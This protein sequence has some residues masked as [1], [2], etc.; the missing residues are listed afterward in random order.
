MKKF[1]II[2]IFFLF[3]IL[4]N[5]SI[6]ET[7]MAMATNINDN[8]YELIFKNEDLNFRN[9]KLKLGIFTSYEYK[10]TKVYIDYKENIKEY[11]VDKEYISFDNTNFNLGIEK[12]KEE[13]NVM[14]KEKYLYDELDKDINDIKISKIELYTTQ[15]ALTKFKSKYPNVIINRISI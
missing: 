5:N 12:L 6:D 4:F 13:Y 3:I 10:I 8:Y 14:L 11:F 9:F 2:S 7:E 1:I 15:D